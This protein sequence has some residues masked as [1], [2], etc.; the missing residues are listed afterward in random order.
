VKKRQ[1]GNSG[2]QVTVLTMGCWQAGGAQWSNT[3][4]DNSIAAIRAAFD[5]GINFFDTAEA[6]GG[7]HSE[8]I[9][10]KALADHKDE[11]LIATKVFPGNYTTEKV[12]EACENS[13]R[14]LQT[15]SIDLY[16]LHWPTGTW[17]TPIVPIEETM[18]A[19][20]KLQ[21]EGKIKAIGVSNFN[22]QQI[23]EALQI[24]RID[25][26]QP[27]YSLFWRPFE[28]NGTIETC[29]KHNIGVIAYSPLAQGL[30]TGKFNKDN[31]P[32]EGDNRAGNA[33]FKGET[34]DKSLAAVDQLRPIADK[35]GK[36]TGELALAWLLAQPG[37][38]S[39]IVGA[40]NADQVKGNTGAAG[41]EI[42]AADV[43]E[44][45]RIGRTVTDSLGDDKTN[46]WAS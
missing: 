14:R 13:L 42:E 25:S 3:D 10:A 36:T 39:V 9:V 43:E 4:D 8:E 12:R 45:N 18:G 21:E 23:E 29:I 16:Q 34:Y 40:R 22:T 46:M 41:F 28:F 5:E 2:L 44:I 19:M 27:P 15:D 17:G 38:T 30:L 7:G 24:G 35:Y 31:K 11:A 37:M 33:L 1:L 6:Y 32:G 26:L 20:V